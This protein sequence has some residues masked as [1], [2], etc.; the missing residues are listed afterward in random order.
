M[1]RTL[2]NSF[3]YFVILCIGIDYITFM[4]HEWY[5]IPFLFIVGILT[6][7]YISK[8]RATFKF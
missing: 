2:K 5:S 3:W 1:K 8:L 6:Y 7:L 4:P